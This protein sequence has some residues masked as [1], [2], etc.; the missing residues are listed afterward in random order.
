MST[1]FMA[2]EAAFG[3][4]PEG[5]RLALV[6]EELFARGLCLPSGSAL[7]AADRERV[8]AAVA[9]CAGARA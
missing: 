4:S 3:A 6:A 7:E 2:A 8:I 9:A 5:I 1:P